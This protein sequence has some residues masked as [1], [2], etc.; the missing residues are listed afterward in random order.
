MALQ[1]VSSNESINIQQLSSCTWDLVVDPNVIIDDIFPSFEDTVTLDLN[2]DNIGNIVTGNVNISSAPNNLLQVLSDGLYAADTQSQLVYGGVVTWIGGYDFHVTAAG[3]YIN[4]IFYTSPETIVTLN[5]PDPLL[6]R[7]DVIYVDTTGVVQVLEGIPDVNP[8]QPGLD[9]GTQLGLG[10]ILVEAGTT[11]PSTINIECPYSEGTEWTPTSSFTI[12]PV[13]P[14]TPCSDSFSIEATST[15]NSEF[16][17]LTRGSSFNINTNY[18]VITFLL[19]PKTDWTGNKRKLN[20]SFRLAGVQ[21]GNIV[22]VGDGLYG[23]SVANT[24]TC[25]VI[26]IPLA[27]FAVPLNEQVDQFYIEVSIQGGGSFGWFMDEVCLQ[28]GLFDIPDTDD[29]IHNQFFGPQTP[30]RFWIGGNA[31]IEGYITCPNVNAF[32]SEKFGLNATITGLGTAATALGALS[33]AGEYSTALGTQSI[34]SG[35]SIAIGYLAQATGASS[36]SINGTITHSG[37]AGIFGIST[38]P[39]QFVVGRSDVPITD[40]YIGTGVTAVNPVTINI[41]SSGALGTNIAA[42]NMAFYAGISTGNATPGSFSWH[43][44]NVGASGATS[45]TVTQKTGLNNSLGLYLTDTRFQL[46][47]GAD[48][49][50]AGD[51]VLGN[52]GNG[53]VVVGGTTIN[54]INDINWQGGAVVYLVFTETVT[55]KHDTAGGPNTNPLKLN[56]SVDF[57]A[58]SN[59]LLALWH[60]GSYWHEIGRKLAGSTG[61]GGVYTFR[62]GLVES[63]ATIVELGSPSAPGAP[64]LHST[65]IDAT[66]S[67]NLNLT[68]AKSDYTLAITNTGTGNGLNV[69]ASTSAYGIYSTGATGVQGNSAAGFAVV[70]NA[71]TTGIGIV[72]DSVDGMAGIFRRT[73]ASVGTTETI[74]TFQRKSS[75]IATD[76]IA[77]SIDLGVQDA[78]G[79]TSVTNQIVSK[80][81]TAAFATRTSILELW[82]VNSGTNLKKA[83]LDSASGFTVYSTQT[84]PLTTAELNTTPDV[85]TVGGSA[86]FAGA[87]RYILPNSAGAT[88]SVTF[89]FGAVSIGDVYV[90]TATS[91][92]M[93]IVSVVFG[94]VTT[95]ASSSAIGFPETSRQHFHIKT[96]STSGVM[97]INLQALTSSSPYIEAISVKRVT[98]KIPIAYANNTQNTLNGFELRSD[99]LTDNLSIG[100]DAGGYNFNELAA[101]T[102]VY[103]CR[104]ISIGTRA[105]ELNTVGGDNIS[106][107][108]E[109]GQ[110]SIDADGQIA[111]G[112]FALETNQSGGSSVA[113]GYRT[114]QTY[115]SAGGASIAIGAF[116]LANSTTA[117]FNVGIGY[118]ALR[119]GTTGG[120]NTAIGSQ[121]ASAGVVTGTANTLI[122]YANAQLISSGAAN[123]SVG[124]FGLNNLTTGQRNTTLGNNSLSIV[125]TGGENIAIGSYA[126]STSASTS[127]TYEVTQ[128]RGNIADTQ[129][130]FIGAESWANRETAVATTNS[131]AIGFDSRV[132]QNH[133]VVLGGN[134]IDSTFLKGDIELRN[135]NDLAANSLADPTFPGGTT[136]W[137][138]TGAVTLGTNKAVFDLN[139]GTT[140]TLTQTQANLAIDGK[141]E[142]WYKMTF[143]ANFDAATSG[144]NSTVDVSISGSTFATVVLQLWQSTQVVVSSTSQTVKIY[145][146]SKVAPTDVTFSF[147]GVAGTDTSRRVFNVTNIVLTEAIGGDLWVNSTLKSYKGVVV[148][149]NQFTPSSA[150][151]ATYPIGSMTA[152]DSFLWYRKSDGNWVKSAWAAF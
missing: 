6:D 107:G 62:N 79:A 76:G 111:I 139:S 57:V 114:L 138:V 35:G 4:D 95:H 110:A 148:L 11:Q 8:A 39:N 18:N 150:T 72:G 96:T 24:S 44:S 67:Y 126:A 66:G 31:K 73:P 152:D 59:D 71:T 32:L 124:Y 15:T 69:T 137:G 147:T 146:K 103:G 63:P 127:T 7:F 143:T 94:G 51:L 46:D 108:Y 93:N 85:W 129:C 38:A 90:I 144:T 115:N 118:Q 98:T 140:G 82:G 12:N 145:F 99:N 28:G 47:R 19:K 13:S 3:Y 134:D 27:H 42:G 130:I 61:T 54:A 88:G 81:S 113:I 109:A 21:K 29:D 151:D 5:P 125:T 80:L 14:N 136:K 120:F 10:L 75:G 104:N 128:V 119:Q 123:T 68:G 89:D 65:Y 41:H 133:Q 60:S 70:G 56:G 97:T 101:A 121:A 25:Q 17:L 52:D 74:A 20:L 49:T 106:I 22:T 78:G 33:S 45:Q 34:A 77:G 102:T 131:I 37:S 105:L 2:Y 83:D 116:A 86:S 92:T 26:S 48:I 40:F 149:E 142:R 84:Q 30:G 141:S 117:G 1:L 23:F 122:G 87:G 132:Y 36:I 43:T 50:A 9:L 100:E 91:N 112:S 58:E 16:L 53:F 64:L 135:F 55:V